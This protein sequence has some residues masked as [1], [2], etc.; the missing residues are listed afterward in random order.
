MVCMSGLGK[1]YEIGQVYRSEPSQTSRHAA[2]FTGVDCEWEGVKSE[3]ELVY[4]ECEMLRHA[5]GEALAFL[6]AEFAAAYPKATVPG[7]EKVI[8]FREAQAILGISGDESL[9]AEQEQER[10]LGR[11]MAEQGHE[12]VALV[13]VPWKQHPF[14]HMKEVVGGEVFTKSF[15][16]LYRGVEITTGA[17]REH[18]HVVLM[19]QLAEKGLTGKGMEFYLDGFKLGAPPHG[20]FGLGL[21]RVV[22]LFLGLASIKEATFIHRGP[23]RLVP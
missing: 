5:M 10:E 18:R 9:S 15:E 16:L 4:F 3:H 23:G 8:A 12:M 21:A 22:M 13:Q 14:Y 20:G 11:I 7:P 1:I 2:E 19:G 17:V 6:G